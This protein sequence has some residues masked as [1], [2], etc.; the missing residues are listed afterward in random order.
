MKHLTKS[1]L[2][3]S[4]L[5]LFSKNGWNQIYG[6]GNTLTST[7][8][9]IGTGNTATGAYSLA[10]GRYSKATQNYN[11]AI[12]Y[13]AEATGDYSY[14]FGFLSK[15]SGYNSFSIGN[16]AESSGHSSYSF[17]SHAH[18]TA[19]SS[20]SIGNYSEANGNN[21]FAFGDY[22][23]TSA[24]NN[25]TIGRGVNSTIK[26]ENSIPNSLAIGF[27]SNIP[28]LFVEGSG[29]AGLTGKVG[30]GTN[31]PAAKL[32]VIGD[33]TFSGQVTA[34]KGIIGNTGSIGIITSVLCVDRIT[35]QMGIFTNAR[36]IGLFAKAGQGVSPPPTNSYGVWGQSWSAQDIACGVH[37]DSYSGA[38]SYGLWGSASGGSSG[39]YGVFANASGINAYAGYFQGNVYSTMMYLGSDKK[40]KENIKPLKNTDRLMLLQPKEYTYKTDEFESMNL[41]QGTHMGFIAQDIEA[42]FPELIKE[43]VQPPTIDKDGKV[44]KEGITFKAVNYVALIPLLT[45]T[46]QEQ[47]IIIEEQKKSISDLIERVNQLENNKSVSIENDLIKTEAELYQNAP[48][49]FNEKT[50][51]KYNLPVTI[52]QASVMIFDMNGTHKLTIEANVLEGQ[53]SVNA[54][55]LS[56]GIYIYSLIADKIEVASKRMIITE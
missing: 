5:F 36:D 13:T 43:T 8:S 55:D 37:G 16:R 35:E 39:N 26:L 40:L 42:I 10:V 41:E 12:G 9:G 6:I 24:I 2:L 21:S 30:I 14:T 18:A 3:V 11:V 49:P 33:G 27:N 48:N 45:A 44:I 15:S 29:G 1:L 25:M 32:H 46:V 7:G 22:V 53:I 56:P 34:Y 47:N 19:S 20:F 50:I 17:G 52:N 28:T 31:N 4:I 23:K 38:Y 51:I 54:K